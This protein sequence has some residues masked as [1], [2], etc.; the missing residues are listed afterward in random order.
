M[1]KDKDKGGK[2]KGKGGGKGKGKGPKIKAYAVML[3][4]VY[5]TEDEAQSI[6]DNLN[7]MGHMA[8]VIET[9]DSPTSGVETSTEDMVAG[10][11]VADTSAGDATT[12]LI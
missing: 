10:E 7:A 8:E 3:S 2:G 6:V 9:N 1:A 11:S 4:T 12:G 5:A